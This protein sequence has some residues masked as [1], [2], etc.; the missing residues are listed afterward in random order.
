MKKYDRVEE[1]DYQ[2]VTALF[3]M[4]DGAEYTREYEGNFDVYHFN[5]NPSIYGTYAKDVAMNAFKKEVI[6][7]D[8]R[9]LIYPC[10]V[11]K[12]E[13]SKPTPNPKKVGFWKEWHKSFF[14]NLILG[15]DVKYEV[16]T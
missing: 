12:I 9:I 16:I 5:E 4:N 3:V 11:K 15:K 10:N 6:V 8:E 13:L 7:V 1:V 2:K 14:L